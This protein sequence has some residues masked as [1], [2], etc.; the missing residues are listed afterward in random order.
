MTLEAV[1]KNDWD[2]DDSQ[3]LS[4]KFMGHF[5]LE[6][7]SVGAYLIQIDGLESGAAETFV[8]VGG[9]GKGASGDNLHIFRGAFAEH[10]PAQGP[11]DNANTIQIT[12]AQHQVAVFGGFQKHGDVIGVMRE[13]SV[14]FENEVVSMIEGPFKSGDI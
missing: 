12:G 9:I 7:V 4:P 3:A 8:V 14:Q 13:I 2:L 6:T 11:I 5:D 10:Q 1:G